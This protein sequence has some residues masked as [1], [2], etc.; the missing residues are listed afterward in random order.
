MWPDDLH[1]DEVLDSDMFVDHRFN[2]VWRYTDTSATNCWPLGIA[3]SPSHPISTF[4][5]F[6]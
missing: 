5:S 3:G 6:Y 1:P 4:S 2:A